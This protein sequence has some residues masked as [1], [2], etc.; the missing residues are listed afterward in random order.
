MLSGGGEPVRK[1]SYAL[2]I[3]ILA[4]AMS[5]QQLQN[6]ARGFD[7]EKSFQMGDYDTVNAFNGNLAV[8]IP[9]GP[10]FSPGG[11]LK[12]GLHLVYN[13][14][15]W[16][17]AGSDTQPESIPN[18]FCNAGLGWQLTLGDLVAPKDP[19][20][21]AMTSAG[22]WIFGGPD[23]AEHV[24]YFILHNEE[25]NTIYAGS[26]AITP[27]TVVGYTRDGSY[28][29]LV[30]SARNGST[31]YWGGAC[32]SSIYGCKD[33]QVNYQIESP[34]GT[35]STFRSQVVTGVANTTGYDA[36]NFL[37][38]SVDET[39]LYQLVRVEDRFGNYLNVTYSSDGLTWTL[40]DGTPT[41]PGRRHTIAL[42]PKTFYDYYG[43][44]TARNAIGS[45]SLAGFQG[46]NPAPL[47][48]TYTFNYGPYES[49]SK[50]CDD[51][52]PGNTRSTYFLNSITQPDGSQFT[53]TYNKLFYDST[54][55]TTC[56]RAAGHLIGLTLPT[57]GRIAYTT[58]GTQSDSD[59]GRCF[60]TF[61]QLDDPNGGPGK[62]LTSTRYHTAA[63]TARTLY[64]ANNVAAG[65]WTWGSVLTSPYQVQVAPGKFQTL[66]QEEIVTATDPLSYTTALHYNVDLTGGGCQVGGSGDGY[67][68]DGY[69][70]PYTNAVQ[71][72]DGLSLS[73]ETFNGSC[74][75][76]TT[77]A[78]AGCARPSCVD[79]NQNPL[80]PVRTSY[81]AYQMDGGLES[82]AADGRLQHQRI[83]YNDDTGC[84]SVCSQDISFDDFDGLG[85][86][87][88]EHHTSNF[89][90]TNERVTTTHFNAKGGSYAVNANPDNYMIAPTGTW[91]PNVFDYTSTSEA[92]VTAE[93]EYCF[94]TATAFLERR[95]TWRYADRTKAS[96]DLLVTYTSDAG[97]V[98]TET[99]YGGD[100][101][102]LPAGF[103]TCASTPY[104]SRYSL[105][106]HYTAGTRDS[107]QYIGAGITFKSLDLTIDPSSG[108]PWKSRDTAGLE[109]TLVY[110]NLNRPTEVHPPGTAWTQYS[111]TP[112][113]GAAPAS[114]SIQQRPNGF[115]TSMP[116]E[117]ESWLYFDAFGR[118]V[119]K[120]VRMPIGGL[121]QW[122]STRTDYDIL[123]RV[124]NVWAPIAKANSSWELLSPSTKTSYLYD[125]FGR[126]TSIS[127]PDLSSTT[128]SYTGARVTNRIQCVATGTQI[129]PCGTSE[130]PL[131]TTETYDGHSR[132]VSVVEPIGTTTTYGYDV[133]NRLTSVNMTGAD[134][135]QQR[136][137]TYDLAGL[138]L[139]EQ[140]P[141]LGVGG[142]GTKTYTEYDAGGHVRHVITGTSGGRFDLTYSYDPAERLT[143]VQD[144]TTTG[145]RRTLKS[146]T[147]ATDNPA[148][149]YRLGKL[150]TAQRHN[151]HTLFGGDVTVTETYFYGG[152][153]GRVS[154]RDT[155]V[156]GISSFPASTFQLILGWNDLG[157]VNSIVY[158]TTTSYSTVAR[159]VRNS[160][161]DGLL[162]SVSGNSFTYATALDR[163]SNGLI[164]SVTH[165][166]GETEQWIADGSGIARPATITVT[167][168]G[169]TL[170]QS[171]AYA[172]DGSGNIKS[173]GDATTNNGVVNFYTYD[174]ASRLTIW[175]QAFPSQVHGKRYNYDSFGNPTSGGVFS[176][177]YGPAPTTAADVTTRH[178]SSASHHHAAPLNYSPV[179]HQ[180]RT[181][182]YSPTNHDSA[183]TYDAAG[184]VVY[185]GSRQFSWDAVPMMAT[186]TIPTSPTP[187]TFDFIY[188]ADDERVAIVESTNGQYKYTFTLRDLGNHVLRSW[189]DDAHTGA[190]VWG[191]KEDEI[192]RGAQLLAS[193]SPTYGTMHFGLD[194]LGSPVVVTSSTGWLLGT[195]PFDPWGSGGLVGAD[196]LKFTGQERDG[197]NLGGNIMTNMPDYFHG[198]SYDYAGVSGSLFDPRFLS[199]DPN[200]DLDAALHQPQ[201]W[202][203][204]SYVSNN[205][206][207]FDDPNG[208][209]Q[210]FRA[211]AYDW[212][213]FVNGIDRLGRFLD[214]A[215]PVVGMGLAIFEAVRGVIPPSAA[216]QEIENE[217]AEMTAA[218]SAASESAMAG[219][220]RNVNPT[221][222]TT[223]CVNC[224]A[225]VDNM[226]ATGRQASALPS[227]PKSIEVLGKAWTSM[228]SQANVTASMTEAGNGARGVVYVGTGASNSVGHV[229]NVVN[230][231]G[232]VRF[233]DGQTRKPVTTW[234]K[235]W[236]DIRLLRTN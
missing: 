228:G 38:E 99:Y 217:A 114:V 42:L 64:D 113:A 79:G 116:T 151:Y 192:W 10:T 24:F 22:N 232:V 189:L 164:T 59:T 100:S 80:T 167:A 36:N 173:I 128:V 117:T 155:A 231:N 76:T 51:T 33:W 41:T 56:S 215:T 54:G 57:G 143:G 187:R 233:L 162:T 89:P 224:A 171:G 35:I 202:N 5:G 124:T 159:T 9:I 18:R 111:Y 193:E 206:L 181:L 84:G 105:S 148:G 15:M 207:T 65:S 213:G 227:G 208:R 97:N 11:N 130:Q 44:A 27:G 178:D 115:G 156:S 45:I 157:Q 135:T 23:G 6:T 88:N 53:M 94:N 163:A 170:F 134:G 62:Q 221:G 196:M 216:A 126:T 31:T 165:G 104:A 34:D 77:S 186:A 223:N 194:H 235:E 73:T 145:V 7:P 140:H 112:A 66:Y 205:P 177:G 93:T 180:A 225:T 190:H 131:T 40:Q 87:R 185:D 138:L 108:L 17:F 86:Y 147:Y 137:F 229:F 96:N 166:N 29:R 139:S 103:V 123:G 182:S 72:A 47:V 32:T 188:T 121:E 21:T 199:I 118:S 2:A 25:F 195:Q 12:Y 78:T 37:P 153:G 132:L 52:Y 191:W 83:V 127:A 152:V 16:S 20:Q 19:L 43:T 212:K 201:R 203:R 75:M 81:V 107:S 92:G 71:T 169:S 154:E 50:S 142:N 106:H 30:R 230:Q 160:Y 234:L 149:N 161:T 26:T 179:D 209:E 110:D 214:R 218:E 39:L 198:R 102:P 69:S 197:Y 74:T 172:Y 91:L 129:S 120:K 14:N 70:L 136:F 55:A 109:T 1:L 101:D 122:A 175:A 236:T 219:S 82:A 168:N 68:G 58:C 63:I 184:D 146:L 119:L 90:G 61:P 48:S 60:R 46:G 67:G 150:M 13:G 98:A 3:V 183:L 144:L 204:Y 28:L 125:R 174:L 95:R 220:I 158:P 141:E 210:R 200:I 8:S 211:A 176:S 4:S 133:G 226:L 49:I 222:S 85:H